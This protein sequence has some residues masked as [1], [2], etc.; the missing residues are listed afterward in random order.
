[1]TAGE[2]PFAAHGIVEAGFETVRE[3][4][5]DVIAAQAGTGA[6]LAVWHDGRWV[7]DLWGGAADAAGTVPWRRDS[8]VQAYSVSKPFVAMC[9]LLLVDRGLLDLDAPVQRYWPEFTAQATVRR[10]RTS[11]TN[12]TRCVH[13]SRRSNLHGRRGPHMASQRSSTATSWVSSCGASTGAASAP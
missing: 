2:A 1:V 7:V 12:G 4:F 8:I 3:A 13:C 9:A 5:S 11:S 10:R 6:A